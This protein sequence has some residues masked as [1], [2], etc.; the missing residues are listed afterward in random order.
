MKIEKINKLLRENLITIEEHEFL[1]SKI[2]EQ[3]KEFSSKAL[4]AFIIPIIGSQP[5]K[6]IHNPKLSTCFSIFQ[7]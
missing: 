6:I 5:S 3:K 2:V 4:A 1:I 7:C